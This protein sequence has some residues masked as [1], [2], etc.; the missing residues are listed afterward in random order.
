L[1]V[2]QLSRTAGLVHGRAEP[3]ELG[4][5]RE[6]EMPFVTIR[7]VEG[8]SQER[9][10]EISRRVTEAISDVTGLPKDGVWIVFEDV[11]TEDWYL[12][13]RTV[14]AVREEKG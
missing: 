11:T 12:G 14:K 1:P 7:I 9:K 8:H 2:R 4:R 5:S 13:G 6:R 3:S 10:D